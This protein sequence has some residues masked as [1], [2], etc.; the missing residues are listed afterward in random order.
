M[1]LVS[2]TLCYTLCF[3]FCSRTPPVICERIFIFVPLNYAFCICTYTVRVHFILLFHFYIYIIGFFKKR[4]FRVSPPLRGWDPPW[5]PQ[6]RLLVEERYSAQEEAPLLK[7]LWVEAAGKLT[8]WCT[9]NCQ[10]LSKTWMYLVNI[11]A[12]NKLKG[13]TAQWTQLICTLFLW[14]ERHY[15]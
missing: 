14:D 8:V 10:I 2:E 5:D 6:L 15:V 9:E 13:L 7:K 4:V 1:T 11:L 3:L 12:Y